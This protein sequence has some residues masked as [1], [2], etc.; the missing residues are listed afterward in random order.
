[1]ALLPTSPPAVEPVTLGEA[2]AHLRIDGS[3]EDTLLQSLVQ[4]A[5]VHLELV[6][7]RAFIT[8]GWTYLRDAWP[9]GRE[10]VLPLA[11]VASVNSVAVIAADGTRATLDPAAYLLDG[12]GSTPRLVLAGATPLPRPGRAG[13]GIEIVLVA[14]HG[15]TG[16]DVPAPLRH[17]ILLLAAHWY[18]N[19]QPVE[20]G[21]A[22][23]PLPL[24]IA[25][26]I[27]P[28]RRRRL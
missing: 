6:L 21:L 3:E 26:L 4:A 13:N 27:A 14:G 23:E 5:R 24:A 7:A 15:S 1:M 20:I 12:S 28:Y 18:E 19:R 11:P 16:A 10:L 25:E 8:Q 22:G 17:A 2:K 9:V